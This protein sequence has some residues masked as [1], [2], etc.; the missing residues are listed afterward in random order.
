MITVDLY[1]ISMEGVI[2]CLGY[3]ADILNKKQNGVYGMS[4]SSS[5]EHEGMRCLFTIWG[6][7]IPIGFMYKHCEMVLSVT[8]V[9]LC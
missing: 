7:I 1:C 9:L 5:D 2:F 3:A 6:T 8:V 4:G